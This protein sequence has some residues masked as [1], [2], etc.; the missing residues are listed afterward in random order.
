MG[1]CTLVDF[2][3]CMFTLPSANDSTHIDIDCDIRFSN[4]APNIARL[5]NKEMLCACVCALLL[6]SRIAIRTD[7]STTR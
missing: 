4:H 7:R 1:S 3:R 6:M 2:A 5:G